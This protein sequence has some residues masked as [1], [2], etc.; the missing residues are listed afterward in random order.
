MPQVREI[1]IPDDAQWAEIA[2]IVDRYEEALS[3]S[4]G[5]DLAA[6]LP[7][8]AS[9]MY[10]RVA[11]ELVRVDLEHRWN[12]GA[13]RPLCEYRALTP[14][15]FRQPELLAEAAFEE[16]RLR[17]L[18]GE[19]IDA[20]EY[21]REYGVSTHAWPSVDGGPTRS[22]TSAPATTQEMPEPG[23]TFAGFKLI[24]EIGRGAFATVFLAEQN[25]LARRP[26]VLKV[27]QRRTLEPQ[28]LARLQHSNIVPIYSVHEEAGL[29]AVCM[30]YCGEQ[31]LAEVAATSGSGRAMQSTVAKADDETV[32][33]APVE[34]APTTSGRGAK[35]HR[36][37]EVNE[38]IR[39]VRDLAE[40]LAHAH[41]RG[42]VHRD[43]KPANVLLADDGRPMLLDF[44]LADGA[45]PGGGES[46]TVGGTLPY[47]APEHLDA[48]L[49]GA[50]VD[51]RCD[52]FS[53]GVILFELLTGRRPFTDWRGSLNTV[54][55]RG[56]IERRAGAPSPRVV[57]P[58]V[59]ASIDS[60]VRKCLAP[61]PDARYASAE[62]LAED[63]TRHLEDLP[64]KHT[65]NPSFTE[66]AQKWRRR[67]PRL[68]SAGSVGLLAALAA[69]VFAGAWAVRA[70]RLARL[71]AAD[72]Y[73]RFQRAATVARA[74][75]SV[76]NI[77]TELLEE[78]VALGDRALRMYR[79]DQAD[80]WRT[81]S[82]YR[83]LDPEQVASVGSG[84]AE[85]AYLLAGAELSIAQADAD[86]SAP[87]DRLDKALAY[88]TLCG[89]LLG[90]SP[91]VLHQREAIASAAGIEPPP[92]PTAAGASG[93]SVVDERLQAQLL[94]QQHNFTEAAELLK[95][96]RDREPTDPVYWLLLGNAEAAT[97]ELSDAEAAL[98]ASVALQPD[99]YVA[100]YNR[101][102]CRFQRQRF[103]GAADDFSTVLA[104]RPDLV[105][106]RLNRAIAYESTG[107]HDDALADL[108][109]AI[110]SGAAPPRAYLIRS[111]VR[112]TVGDHA[113]AESDLE[114]GLAA[115][116]GDEAGWVARG[117]A[118]LAKDPQG[119]LEDFQEALRR[120]PSSQLA[121]KNIV[122]VTADRLGKEDDALAALSAWIEL[123]PTSDDALIGRAVLNARRGER[124]AALRDLDAALALSQRPVTLF[125][126][127]C[128]LSRTGEE[129]ESDLARGM[130]YLSRALEADEPLRRRAAGDPDLA[131]LRQTAGYRRLMTAY[132]GVAKA[133]RSLSQD[134][135]SASDSR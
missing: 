93:E 51:A 30:P 55:A 126:A 68:T 110:D 113:G 24:R 45:V 49:S 4:G 14:G 41:R 56:A 52:L 125:Q 115:E 73:E 127:A 60:L 33:G 114:A 43:L 37:F 58:E 101:G 89:E 96:L 69:C 92:L 15:L 97:G 42:I 53:L 38:A 71:E 119:A 32:R 95:T 67:H 19:S 50:P 128:V 87:D 70:D 76:P 130:G 7:E 25:D 72:H 34:P 82:I 10:G 94:L 79:P 117:V 122:H 108:D 26:V 2:E 35:P 12:A 78:G 124:A 21:A 133:K 102:L 20:Q 65:P 103:D 13:A 57:A 5:V 31:T 54:V 112:H 99:S 123:D 46:L 39:L 118:R 6:F 17:R 59:P 85:V 18:A 98:T 27:S 105:C 84:L 28:H 121:L 88:N 16:F 80:R 75:L 83:R 8:P 106:A 134:E 36:R 64:L 48:V 129:D 135:A 120:W 11:V 81:A 111:R 116:P 22:L 40:G 104:A 100:L 74:S 109:A 63:L 47:M 86:D 29:I 9:P 23:E 1:P 62:A 91:A 90:R 132:L 107:R 3:R 66:R 131:Q 44:N 77:D 61:A